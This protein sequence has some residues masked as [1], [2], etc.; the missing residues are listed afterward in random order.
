MADE[1]LESGSKDSEGVLDRATQACVM[2]GRHKQIQ[3]GMTNFAIQA[4]AQMEM[5]EVL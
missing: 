4:D 3:K 2:A 5:L 1:L